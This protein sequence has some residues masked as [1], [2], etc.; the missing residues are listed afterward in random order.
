MMIKVLQ[1]VK[2]AASEKAPF[3]LLLIGLLAQK[4]VNGWVHIR[5]YP[6]ME[7]GPMCGIEFSPPITIFLHRVPAARFRSSGHSPAG[8][9]ISVSFQVRS[10][11]QFPSLKTIHFFQSGRS[12]DSLNF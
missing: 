3:V 1:K 6:W 7:R 11:H 8:C 2:V 10:I 4:G 12:F 5:R 9:K